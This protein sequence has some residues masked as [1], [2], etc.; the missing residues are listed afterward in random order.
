MR[1]AVDAGFAP[2][3]LSLFFGPCQ[4]PYVADTIRPA[5]SAC[6]PDDARAKSLL[7][8][9]RAAPDDLDGC[10]AVLGHGYSVA[11]VPL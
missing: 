10:R 1:V 3:L 4:G 11:N 2:A 9:A 6:L 7:A 5:S 8:E